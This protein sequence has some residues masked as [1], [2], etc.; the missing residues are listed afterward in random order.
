MSISCLCRCGA[1]LLFPENAVGR[2]ARCRKCQSVFTV[3]DNRP[4][5]ILTL[6][7]FM[8]DMESTRPAAAPPGATRAEEESAGDGQP[9]FW[10]DLL[11]SLLVLADPGNIIACLV[12]VALNF[13][14]GLIGHAVPFGF[15]PT[16]VLVI[17]AW[18][19]VLGYL[20]SFYLNTIL[21]TAGGE[22]DLP[23]L[24]VDNIVEDLLW[25]LLQFTG[26]WLFAIAPAVAA[27]IA[28][29]WW[30]L[31]LPQNLITGLGLVGGFMWPAIVLVVALGNGFGGLWP[32][33][34]VRTMLVAPLS[35]LAIVGVLAVGAALSLL[36]SLLAAVGLGPLGPTSERV[37]SVTT[38]LLA[39]VV[40]IV[41]MR[42]IGLYYRHYK[43]RL[44]FEAE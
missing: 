42:A 13:L 29:W 28:S 25:P 41:S 43:I 10:G 9:W 14:Q 2:K 8:E 21:E 11:D 32:H 40:C 18:G 3:P 35:Y 17:G 24:R 36:P 23:T 31:D 12:I 15:G 22:D 5:D 27:S 30:S 37:I 4:V 16:W 1:Q 39:P 6:A 33:L 34:L 20:C 26:S 7:P 44:P 19:L 38:S